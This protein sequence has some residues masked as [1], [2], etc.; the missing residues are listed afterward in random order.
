MIAAGDRAVN[1]A[2]GLLSR[3]EPSPAPAVSVAV[4][5]EVRPPLGAALLSFTSPRLVAVAIVMVLVVLVV[6]VTTDASTS[7]VRNS[8]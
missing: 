4:Q 5:D 1:W 3:R 8:V 2:S 6:L 7:G